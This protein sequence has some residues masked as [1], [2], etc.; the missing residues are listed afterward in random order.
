[1][2]SSFGTL[3]RFM[4]FG[5]SHGPAVGVV[6]DGVAPGIT[7]DVDEIQRELDRRRPGKGDLAADEFA[8]LGH[9]VGH[10]IGDGR[11]LVTPRGHVEVPVP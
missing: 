2:S 5:E 7:V 10:E 6:L 3:F 11:V 1:M 4:T 9:G 8:E